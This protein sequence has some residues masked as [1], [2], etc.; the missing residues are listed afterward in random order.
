MRPIWN[1]MARPA[2]IAILACC[3]FVLG[4]E[5]AKATTT[6]D[7]TPD[8]PADGTTTLNDVISIP[9]SPFGGTL[10][11][12][13]TLGADYTSPGDASPGANGSFFMELDTQSTP[14]WSGA[15]LLAAPSTPGTTNYGDFTGPGGNLAV[16]LGNLTDTSLWTVG[17]NPGDFP[18]TLTISAL[19]TGYCGV[20]GC[21]TPNASFS[22]DFTPNSVSATPLPAALPLFASGMGLMG[23]VGWRRK[24]KAQAVEA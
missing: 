6:V 2:S 17:I 16:L 1:L 5:R 15:T 3:L 4:D 19:F 21:F 20:G 18:V 9:G 23:W 11:F 24:R 14:F 8:S 10:S 13:L 22:Y 7:F 12:N